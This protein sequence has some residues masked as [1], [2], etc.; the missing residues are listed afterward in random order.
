[1]RVLVAAMSPA[2]HA[3]PLVPPCPLADAPPPRRTRCEPP[4][5]RIRCSRNGLFE[6]IAHLTFAL[7]YASTKG[8]EQN[9][10]WISAVELADGAVGLDFEYRLW[11]LLGTKRNESTKMAD[12][13]LRDSCTYHSPLDSSN[14]ISRVLR[15]EIGPVNPIG[16]YLSRGSIGGSVPRVAMLDAYPPR[17]RNRNRKSTQGIYDASC[18]D[19]ARRALRVAVSIG[20]VPPIPGRA[21]RGDENIVAERRI[22]CGSVT[23][24]GRP[25]RNGPR[26]F[27]S[28]DNY[29]TT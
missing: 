22:A 12:N 17:R 14:R 19:R 4:F 18:G 3:L 21:A 16:T 7:L 10:R 29:A 13:K 5:V 27:T 25:T 15:R 2:C 24:T 11:L 23:E 1:M 20:T 28:A 26:Y 6:E 9:A 8:H